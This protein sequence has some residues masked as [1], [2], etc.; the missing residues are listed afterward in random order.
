MVRR[1]HLITYSNSYA[2]ERMV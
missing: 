2:V 1:C